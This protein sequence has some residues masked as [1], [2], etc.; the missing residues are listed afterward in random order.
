MRAEQ[1]RAAWLNAASRETGVDAGLLRGNTQDEI[2]EHARA[3]RAA[4]NAPIVRDSGEHKT[5]SPTKESILAIK[6]EKERLAAIREN[7]ELF[8]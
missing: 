1:E 4:Y 7:A 5:V 8:K 6:N 3:I 2:L